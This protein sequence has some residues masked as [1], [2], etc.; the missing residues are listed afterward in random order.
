MKVR[1]LCV[2]ALLLAAV[3]WAQGP[4]GAQGERGPGRRPGVMGEVTAIKGNEI[5]LK[6]MQGETATV[7]ITPE[8]QFR[9][10]REEAKLG[11]IKVGDTIAVR[12]E[13]NG[14]TVAAQ[15]VMIA[16]PGGFGGMRGEGRGEG[17]GRGEG[18]PGGPGTGL[19]RED[20]GKTFIAGEVTKIDGTKLTIKR[21]DGETQIVQADEQTSFRNDKRES[22]TLADIKVGDHVMGRGELK[23]G[24][25]VPSV[26]NVGN[27]GR[28]RGPRSQGEEKPQQ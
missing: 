28:M 4:P 3:A 16:P 25:F 27:F 6:T 9:K 10:Q 5:T 7:K 8:T 2:W 20:L 1:S 11:D 14:D 18:G 15:M 24:V 12:G 13:R 21:P 23:N 22:I 26:L 17:M 19:N